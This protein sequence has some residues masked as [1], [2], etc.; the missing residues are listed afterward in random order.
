MLSGET[1]VGKHPNKAIIAM[2]EVCVGAEKYQVPHRAS[3]RSAEFFDRVDEAIAM[4][5]MYTANHLNVK[6]IVALTES[7]S[8]ARWMS[9]V[10]SDIPIYALTPHEATSR[11]VC[12]YRGV[13]PVE[14]EIDPS[15]ASNL[16]KLYTDIFEVLFAD[17]AIDP[18]DLVIFTKGDFD[19][20]S[21]STNAMKILEAPRA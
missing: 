21:G 6:A 4:A 19:G 3:Q 16:N 12:L 13:Y 18:G 5:T 2:A 8:T 1:A 17:D 20:V 11:R 15:H 7:G 10:R 9:R 14:F